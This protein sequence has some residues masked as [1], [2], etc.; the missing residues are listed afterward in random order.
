MGATLSFLVTDLKDTAP[1]LIGGV[2]TKLS[3]SDST[4]SH[5]RSDTA[6]AIR[7]APN[8]PLAGAKILRS[9]AHQWI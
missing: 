5:T 6:L 1:H 7:I 2:M 9:F 3:I 8:D 4:M